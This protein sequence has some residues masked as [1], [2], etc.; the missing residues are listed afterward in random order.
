MV[1]RDIPITDFNDALS[2]LEP[3]N[4][5]GYLVAIGSPFTGIELYGPVEGGLFASVDEAEHWRIQ[6]GLTGVFVDTSS[7]VAVFNT[8]SA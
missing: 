2:S 4:L 5:G 1:T 8:Y 6:N 7:V 3:P